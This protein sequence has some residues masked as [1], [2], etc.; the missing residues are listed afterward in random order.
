MHLYGRG[1]CT[2]DTRIVGFEMQNRLVT[3]VAA[4]RLSSAVS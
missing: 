2:V 1:F 4:S 3:L